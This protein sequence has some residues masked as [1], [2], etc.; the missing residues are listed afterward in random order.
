MKVPLVQKEENGQKAFALL[1]QIVINHE[2]DLL[3]QCSLLTSQSLVL[4]S[5]GHFGNS[6]S[7]FKIGIG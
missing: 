1:A 6:N 7:H 3:C 5:G 2:G 4:I